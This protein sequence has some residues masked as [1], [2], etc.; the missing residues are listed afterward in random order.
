MKTYA[1]KRTSLAPTGDPEQD[2]RNALQFPRE[3][4]TG[5]VVYIPRSWLTKYLALA[6][7]VKELDWLRIEEP[8]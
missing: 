1:K 8:Q 7:A 5:G 2:A 6:Q 4:S 3:S